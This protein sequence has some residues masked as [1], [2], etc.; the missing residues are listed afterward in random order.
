MFE[1]TQ[2]AT[3]ASSP[4][5]SDGSWQ[6]I[7]PQPNTATTAAPSVAEESTAMDGLNLPDFTKMWMVGLGAERVGKPREWDGKPE[8]YLTLREKFFSF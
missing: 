4:Q 7:E 1:Q 5:R 2:Q 8:G 3:V 6:T